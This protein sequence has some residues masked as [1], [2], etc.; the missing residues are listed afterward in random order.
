ME[1]VKNFFE[2]FKI[3]FEILK[4]E[5]VSMELTT[6]HKWPIGEE[7]DFESGGKNLVT[8]KEDLQ[9]M[10]SFIRDEIQETLEKLYEQIQI[11]EQNKIDI[12][13]EPEK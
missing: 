6:K 13:N 9:D 12:I 3:L 4:F 8:P 10:C 2:D 11:F 7:F 5:D 1:F